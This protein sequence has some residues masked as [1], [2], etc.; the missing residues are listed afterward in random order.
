MTLKEYM[1]MD[2]GGIT[3]WEV[4]YFDGSDIQKF[5]GEEVYKQDL[6]NREVFGFGI[7]LGESDYAVIC[8]VAVK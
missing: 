6:Q 8:T 2:Y 4:S 3:D 5:R 1:D 7:S